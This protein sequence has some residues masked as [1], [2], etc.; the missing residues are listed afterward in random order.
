M[1][2]PRPIIRQLDDA[3]ARALLAASHVGRLGFVG[4]N[5]V[6]IEPVLYAAEGDWIFGRTS[7]GV[8]S[9]SLARRP[10]CAFEVD[11]VV[12]P[13]EWRSVV[14]KGTF[15]LLDPEE[16]SP[17]LFSRAMAS[18]R[19]VAPAAFGAEDPVPTRSKLFGI[20]VYSVTGRGSEVPADGRVPSPL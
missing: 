3:E 14:V 10:M 8:K 13:F 17:A 18:V 7:A 6:D 1:S 4:T 20:F 15:H 5:G 12:G 9:S 2:T 11:D 16:E 19:A